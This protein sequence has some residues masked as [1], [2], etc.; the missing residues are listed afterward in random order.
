[1]ASHPWARDATVDGGDI[2]ATHVQLPQPEL[3][4]A[5]EGVYGLHH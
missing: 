1:M 4:L 3:E 2:A 5:W